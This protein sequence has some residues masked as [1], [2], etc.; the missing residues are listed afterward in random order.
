[1]G[2]AIGEEIAEADDTISEFKV[3]FEGVGEVEGCVVARVDV[4]DLG[5]ELLVVLN[6][7]LGFTA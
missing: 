7:G 2:I 1:M 3:G 5:D 6:G 4:G